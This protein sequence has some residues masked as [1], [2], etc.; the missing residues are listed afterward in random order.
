MGWPICAIAGPQ[1][2]SAVIEQRETVG[3]QLAEKHLSSG[4][5][6]ILDAITSLSSRLGPIGTP[7]WPIPIPL[8]TSSKPIGT[9]GTASDEVRTS[10]WAGAGSRS[11]AAL[12]LARLLLP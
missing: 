10:R 11:R 6:F 4:G 2:A 3:N 12:L 7:T 9:S 5:H 1:V 8:R